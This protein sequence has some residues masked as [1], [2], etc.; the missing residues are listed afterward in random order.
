MFAYNDNTPYFT[1]EKKRSRHR[2]YWTIIISEKNNGIINNKTFNNKQI[3]QTLTHYNYWYTGFWF[4]TCLY[5]CCR[6]GHVF[7]R[8]TYPHTSNS[9]VTANCI[10]NL[11]KS[12]EKAKQKAL[13]KYRYCQIVVSRN[14]ICIMFCLVLIYW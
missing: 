5:G 2:N 1:V 8:P 4:R 12:I 3:R 13:P 10:K 14:H 9:S 11:L 6:V 7:E